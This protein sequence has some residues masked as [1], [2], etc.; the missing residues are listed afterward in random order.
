MK[1][2][3]ILVL[4][5]SFILQFTYAQRVKFK[6]SNG[7]FKEGE[8]NGGLFNFQDDNFW[9][10][11]GSPSKKQGMIQL[12]SY[13]LKQFNH[14]LKV[15]NTQKLPDYLPA[16]FSTFIFGNYIAFNGANDVHMVNTTRKENIIVFTDKEFNMVKEVNRK[17]RN[18]NF[19][20]TDDFR[21]TKSEDSTKLIAMAFVNENA[22][23][24]G[25]PKLKALIEVYDSKLEVIWQK[26]FYTAKYLGDDPRPVRCMMLRDNRIIIITTDN[27]GSSSKLRVCILTDQESEPQVF[28]RVFKYPTMSFSY[29]LK[30]PETIIIGGLASNADRA[31]EMF[32]LE[33]NLNK[34][35]FV[36]ENSINLDKTFTSSYPDISKPLDKAYPKSS[37]YSTDYFIP[38]GDGSLMVF[39]GS[40]YLESMYNPRPITFVSFNTEG[41]VKWVKLIP[42]FLETTFEDFT[43]YKVFVQDDKLQIFYGTDP[44]T[45]G[46]MDVPFA[47]KNIVTGIGMFYSELDVNGK[48]SPG[49]LL[50]KS[51]M[52]AFSYSISGIHRM[53]DNVFVTDCKLFKNRMDHKPGINLGLITLIDK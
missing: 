20:Y 22:G 7:I 53:S 36:I 15:I 51:N 37:F 52:D 44:E 29:Y 33:F 12:Y 35:D 42:R 16:Y 6:M 18:E 11:V 47:A 17:V 34:N 26:S 13:S 5:T 50:I 49:K 48:L 21:L 24:P 19:R 32:Y 2:I 45:D 31:K 28:S 30:D 27:E 38:F 14:D 4:A 1:R 23:K 43:S 8:I 10:L 41:Q 39:D 46:K 3:T 9:S 40:Y 25:G